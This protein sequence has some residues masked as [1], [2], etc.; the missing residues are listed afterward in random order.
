MVAILYTNTDQI[1]S[2]AGLT[3]EDVSDAFLTARDMAT[4]LKVD[5][6]SWLP[7]HAALHAD[8]STAAAQQI[9]DC[10][11]L[12]CTYTAAA[13]VLQS[14]MSLLAKITDGAN[15]AE[16]F[17]IDWEAAA[18]RLLAKAALMKQQLVDLTTTPSSGLTVKFF[19]GDTPSYDPVTG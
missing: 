1:R 4:E 11:G 3:V 10:I 5:L 12:Y 2:V 8:T 14:P 9:S 19:S 15:A 18:E 13:W 7:N 6:Y 17:Q 16:R